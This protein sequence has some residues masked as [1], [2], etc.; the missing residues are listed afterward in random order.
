LKNQGRT[1]NRRKRNSRVDH[2]RGNAGTRGGT[3]GRQGSWCVGRSRRKRRRTPSPDARHPEKGGPNGE[4]PTAPGKKGRVGGENLAVQRPAGKNIV[5]KEHRDPKTAP[6]NENEG[7]R[8]AE[9]DNMLGNLTGKDSKKKS[10]KKKKEN[11]ALGEGP[12]SESRRLKFEGECQWGGSAE[13]CL[14]AK[15]GEGASKR[16]KRRSGRVPAP[17]SGGQDTD[18]SPVI[19]VSKKTRQGRAKASGN[20]GPASAEGNGVRAVGSELD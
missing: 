2:S 16:T 14:E 5:K 8:I 10:M 1:G 18:F 4:K 3:S 11:L 9:K 15:K 13:S 12:W 20:R 7:G 19:K 6:G 17:R